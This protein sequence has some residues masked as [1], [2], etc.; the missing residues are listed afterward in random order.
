[1]INLLPQEKREAIMYA[2]RNT[3]LLHWVVGLLAVIA[4]I[5]AFW[6]F[7]Y[8][9]INRSITSYS[10]TIDTK[11]SQLQTA[12]FKEAEDRIKDFSNN[13]K[14]ILQVLSQQVVFSELFQQIGTIMPSGTVLSA[15][16]ISE[17]EGGIDLSIQARTYE[18][19]TQTQ[20]NFEDPANT[21]FKDVDIV[22]VACGGDSEY[23]CTVRLRA[24]FTDEN[25]FL[26][27]NQ[28]QKEKEIT[29]E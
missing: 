4:V 29:N 15:I 9:Y 18:T 27:L 7:G 22:S 13:I 25:P 23:P 21:L 26:F 16:D 20:V 10:S 1:M 24:Q 2:R 19:A 17:V 14:L 3:K 28:A 5:T 8:V 6:T 11:E 12:E